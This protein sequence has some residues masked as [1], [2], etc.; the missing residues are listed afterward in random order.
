M[1][2]KSQTQGYHFIDF[3]DALK[4]IEELFEPLEVTQIPLEESL[5]MV[6]AEDVICHEGHPPFDR[7]AMDG[8]AVRASDV[9]EPG[10]KLKLT[11]TLKAGDSDK[12]KIEQGTCMAVMTGAPIPQGADSV[13]IQE[14]TEE[15]E[16]E[17]IFKKPAKKGANIRFAGEDIKAG[18]IACKQGTLLTPSVIGTCAL[19]GKITVK[20]FRK[21]S[22]SIAITG[23]EIVESGVKEVPYGFIRNSNGPL[24]VALLR[25]IGITPKYLGIIPD[26]PEKIES[27]FEEGLSCDLMLIT[28]GVS[29]GKFDYVPEVMEKMGLEYVWKKIKIKPGKPITFASGK[30]GKKGRVFGLPGN[31]VSAFTSFHLFVKPAIRKMAGWK[32]FWREFE[33]KLAKSIPCDPERITITP[34]R[35]S[36]RDGIFELEPVKFN[37]SADIKGVSAGDCL[38]ILPIKDGEIKKGEFVRF[39]P[40]ERFD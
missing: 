5:G 38:A 19:T 23:D 12:V 11:T 10:T 1:K 32:N 30:N 39:V 29:A 6:L 33:G 27:A 4:R 2:T 31:P 21:P 3:D 37:G 20:V 14:D 25:E 35:C 17:I 16:G 15:K 7:S 18:E 24:L 26:A 22:V 9:K 34:C 13:V 28:G 40:V 36:M 8:F